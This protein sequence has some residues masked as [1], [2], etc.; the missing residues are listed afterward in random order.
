MRLRPGKTLP[1]CPDVAAEVEAGTD[2]VTKGPATVGEDVVEGVVV[3]EVHLGAQADVFAEG[4]VSAT[5]DAVEASP[6][7]FETGRGEPRD[8]DFLKGV[9]GMGDGALAEGTEGRAQEQRH[10]GEVPEGELWAEGERLGRGV[11]G[12]GEAV[13][14]WQKTKSDVLCLRAVDPGLGSGGQKVGGQ[15]LGAAGFAVVSAEGEPAA[16]VHS[17]LDMEAVV[18][19]E[20]EGRAF[21]V[22][23]AGEYVEAADVGLLGV[24]GSGGEQ[25]ECCESGGGKKTGE[26]SAHSLVPLQALV[27]N[28]R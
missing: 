11:D 9:G 5:A 25:H 3:N 24:S 27:R 15:Q 19:A 16:R 10:F 18:L 1:V 21:D 28:W 2:R 13:I 12:D 22:R 6:V 20:A 17:S 7:E 4:E 14:G 8:D 26:L 23:E